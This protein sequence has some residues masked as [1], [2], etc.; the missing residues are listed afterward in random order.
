MS[1]PFDPYYKWLGIA[2]KDQPPNHYRLLGITVFEADAEVIEAAAN[3]QMSYLEEF[4]SGAEQ[5]NEAQK[6][7]GEVSRARV[8]LLNAEQKNEYDAQLREELTAANEA[9][10]AEEFSEETATFAAGDRSAAGP[11][12]V[13]EGISA[14]P[15]N[16]PDAEAEGGPLIPLPDGMEASPHT[17]AHPRGEKQKLVPLFV[18]AIVALVLVGGGITFYL[19]G[20]ANKQEQQLAQRA[21]RKAAQKAAAEKEAERKQEETEARIAEADRKKKEKEEA[22]KIAAAERKQQA[23]AAKTAETQRKE[24]E[25]EAKKAEAEQKAEKKEQLK[26]AKRK[27]EAALAALKLERR[28]G[29]KGEPIW[30]LQNDAA[31]KYHTLQETRSAEQIE[32][33]E[34]SREAL[35]QEYDK[36]DNDPEVKKHLQ[37]AGGVLATE[38]E[39]PFWPDEVLAELKESGL[40]EH[41]GDDHTVWILADEAKFLESL[42]NL[43]LQRDEI[44]QLRK[45]GKKG[46]KEA[47]PLIEPFSKDF[48]SL[49]EQYKTSSQKYEDLDGKDELIAKIE[50]LGNRLGPSLTAVAWQ[51][52]QN[53]F[54][55]V[56]KT[57]NR[58]KSAGRRP[59]LIYESNAILELDGTDATQNAF[60]GQIP[61]PPTITAEAV[62]RL[63][64]G[65]KY[66]SIAGIG[67]DNGGTEQGWQLGYSQNNF[68][69]R[70]STTGGR[71]VPQPA[72]KT[73]HQG[74]KVHH[75]VGTYNGRTMKLY[76]DGVEEASTNK[77]KGPINYPRAASSPFTIGAHKDSD[78]YFEVNGTIYLVRVYNGP[79]NDAQVAARY[80]EVKE[81]I[82]ELNN[83]P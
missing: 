20:E 5:I 14:L 39:L 46:K 48:S 33:L 52:K 6:L 8:C 82:D 59:R 26:Q 51:K 17:T 74:Q 18:L 65:R 23:K 63:K 13:A 9:F 24:R 75:V 49:K 7:L 21:K 54:A 37:R 42:E 53:Y 30:Y 69:L 80:D 2:P 71:W 57:P 73:T 10:V 40:L 19:A 36:L 56:V 47:K 41:A 45:K 1:E 43:D 67:L 38:N 60:T 58:S 32:P 12:A 50:S 70:I 64:Q 77:I 29:E 3:R 11:P 62:V 61:R 34:A 83:A 72:S 55:K 79:L 78:E 15:G 16:G 31:A 68:E 27:A 4:T 22:A 76:V 25:A 35:L 81:K 44:F 28:K 66:G